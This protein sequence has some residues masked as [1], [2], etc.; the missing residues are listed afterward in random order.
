MLEEIIRQRIKD[1][2]FDDPLK[3][4]PKDEEL[5]KEGRDD[6]ILN[7]ERS[8]KGIAELY[9]DQ[10][11]VDVLHYSRNPEEEK[12]KGELTEL[13][14]QLFHKLNQLCNFHFTPAYVNTDIKVSLPI[15]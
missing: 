5:E 4:S 7:Y 2:I 11:K 14:K 13:T 12:A 9:E 8:K 3:I 10:Y 1:E 6:E 15:T